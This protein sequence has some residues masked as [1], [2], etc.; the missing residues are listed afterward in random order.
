MLVGCHRPTIVAVLLFVPCFVA[1]MVSAD[2]PIGHW[3][4]SLAGTKLEQQSHASGGTTADARST[5]TW[6]LC[7]DGTFRSTHSATASVVAPGSLSLSAN[8]VTHRGRWSVESREQDAS[9]VLTHRDGHTNSYRLTS[10]GQTTYLDGQPVLQTRS[11]LC[12]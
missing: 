2:D 8:Q 7:R 9:L 3:K 1:V 11:R 4:E 10:D 12:P 5:T 6:H